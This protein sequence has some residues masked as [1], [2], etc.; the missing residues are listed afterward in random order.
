[1]RTAFIYNDIFRNS[2]F[3]KNHP[4]TINRVS[5]VFDL[6]K[7]I[8][9]EKID[10]LLSDLASSEELSIFHD[11]DYIK[12]LRKTEAS[13]KISY[14]NSIKYNI[15]S[16]S[17]PIFKEMYKR[18]A[19]STGCLLSA[20]KLILE[21]K[22]NLIFSPGSGAHHGQKNKASGFCYFNDI[23]TAI[24]FLKESG[25]RKILY[26]DMDAH[27]GD[28]VVE[29]FKGDKSILTISI[30]QEDLWPRSGEYL[31]KKD[32]INIPV[33]AGF[34]DVGFKNLIRNKLLDQMKD[35]NPE[36]AFLQMGA[37][38]LKDDYMSKLLLSNN[39]MSFI[40]KIF[41]TFTKNI[42]VM[43]GGGYNPWTTLRAWTYNLATLAD[44][45]DKLKIQDS[46]KN[47]LK[48]IKWKK[49]P[50]YEW[51]NQIIDTPNIFM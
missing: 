10:Y 22:Y 30:H 14:F 21:N 26:F 16:P 13:Q 8:K 25:I 42:I 47:F 5:N 9:F 45:T 31:F 33:K 39:S 38:C 23:A 24:L 48:K 1:M 28:G 46:A 3:G 34:D 15:G 40:I 43:G 20:S 7:I 17:N 29:N 36:V 49:K 12:V 4:V 51:V 27:Y 44:E 18:H 50:K 11:K 19:A 41:K 37:D 6:S 2:I 32:V 35:F